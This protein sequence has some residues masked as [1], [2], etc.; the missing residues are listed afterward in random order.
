MKVI[1]SSAD[2]IFEDMTNS[3][4]IVKQQVSPEADYSSLLKSDEYEDPELEDI[5]LNAGQH[6]KLAAVMKKK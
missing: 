4:G 6:Q 2:Q 5:N 1:F 3:Q